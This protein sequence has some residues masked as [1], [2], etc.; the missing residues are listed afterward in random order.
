MAFNSFLMVKTGEKEILYRFFSLYQERARVKLSTFHKSQDR[1]KNPTSTAKL[2]TR[3]KRNRIIIGPSIFCNFGVEIDLL[4]NVKDPYGLFLKL[5]KAPTVTSLVTFL[6]EHS[7]LLFRLGA[8]MLKYA[9]PVRPTYPSKFRVRDLEPKEVGQL[10]PDKFPSSWD[11]LDWDIYNSMRN[12]NVSFPG[13][14]GELGVTWKT[15]RERFYR[16]LNECK[17]WTEFFPRGK[18]AYSQVFLTFK[19]DFEVDLRNQLQKLN[20]TSILY[21]VGDTILLTL[22]LLNN[23]EMYSF[24]K[25]E[26]KGLIRDLEVS[27]PV[28]Y[29]SK[30]RRVD[31]KESHPRHQVDR[32]LQ[33]VQRAIL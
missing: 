24:L 18:P 28:I 27:I 7:L 23:L 30:L 6:G 31:P 2:L 11:D 22:Y 16:M 9:E 25:L 17:I 21:K 1:Y 15:V 26:K 14:A 3:A 20:R 8:S 10:T 12:P 29:W 5:R 33:G 4:K 19:T 32:L 13:V